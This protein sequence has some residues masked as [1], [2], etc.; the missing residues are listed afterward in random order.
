MDSELK[1]LALK[2][3]L[4]TAILN[5]IV[6]VVDASVDLEK[7]VRTSF[8]VLNFDT[9]DEKLLTNLEFVQAFGIARVKSEELLKIARTL[10]FIKKKYKI[11]DF[12][13]HV[14]LQGLDEDEL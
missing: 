2:T 8:D 4:D 13:L 3:G 9:D 14:L 10:L 1:K 7:A 6:G 12:E 11:S 5:E